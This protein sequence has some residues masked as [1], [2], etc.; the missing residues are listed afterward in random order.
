[1]KWVWKLRECVSWKLTDTSDSFFI[2][3]L[4]SCVMLFRIINISSASG[5]YGNFGQANYSTAKMGVVG[6]MNTLAVEGKKDNIFVNTIAP[7]ALSRMTKTLSFSGMY[8]MYYSVFFCFSK[9]VRTYT[10]N[11]AYKIAF[12]TEFADIAWHFHRYEQISM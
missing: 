1:M 5:I 6:L 4:Y 2:E 12:R 8:L 10:I 3:Q 7:T 9:Y 11:T